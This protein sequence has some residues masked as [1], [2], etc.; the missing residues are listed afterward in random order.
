MNSFHHIMMMNGKPWILPCTLG[1]LPI[2]CLKE[3][4]D[5]LIPFIHIY[6][7]NGGPFQNFSC[8]CT[9][10]SSHNHDSFG[11]IHTCHGRMNQGFMIY[12]FIQLTTLNGIIHITGDT[13]M[14]ALHHFHMCISFCLDRIY[15]RCIVPLIGDTKLGP[16]MV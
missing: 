16:G 14:R 11:P 15:N 3:L 12:R 2:F 9:F 13:P 1:P 8:C 6:L 4:Y 5:F 10:S 7:F